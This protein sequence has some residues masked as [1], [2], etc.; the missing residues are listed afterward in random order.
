M[1]LTTYM[2]S[3]AET[4]AKAVS[5]LTDRRTLKNKNKGAGLFLHYTVER[6]SAH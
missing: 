3:L 1:H 6:V 5:I 2:I 4:E